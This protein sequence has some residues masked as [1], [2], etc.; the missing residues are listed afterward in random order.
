MI[1]ANGHGNPGQHNEDFCYEH[2]DSYGDERSLYAT[3]FA[4]IKIAQQAK[5]HKKESK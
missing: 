3:M 2:Q 1:S 5:W 4:I